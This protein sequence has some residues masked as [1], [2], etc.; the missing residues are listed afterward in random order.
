MLLAKLAFLDR[1]GQSPRTL[2]EAEQHCIGPRVDGLAA[3][4]VNADGFNGTLLRWRFQQAMSL[5]RENGKN[6]RERH[7]HHLKPE[8]HARFRRPRPDAVLGRDAALGRSA[9]RGQRPLNSRFFC[10]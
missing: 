1:A 5:Q 9:W 4:A 10:V 3:R 8:Q 2:L 7:A 6:K